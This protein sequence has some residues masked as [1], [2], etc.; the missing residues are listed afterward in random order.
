VTLAPYI[1]IFAFLTAI[2]MFGIA[3]WL[4][5]RYQKKEKDE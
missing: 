1:I 2:V 3:L 4:E 5:A